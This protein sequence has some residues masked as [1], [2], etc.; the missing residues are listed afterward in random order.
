MLSAGIL[1]GTSFFEQ[2]VADSLQQ[3]LT[4]VIMQEQELIQSSEDLSSSLI[5]SLIQAVAVETLEEYRLQVETANAIE[6]RLAELAE[7]MAESAQCLALEE[8]MVEAYEFLM[9][10]ESCPLVVDSIVE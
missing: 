8:T 10:E 9:F 1:I 3:T 6:D 2:V 4:S 7:E 5:D